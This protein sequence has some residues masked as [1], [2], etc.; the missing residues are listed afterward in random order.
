MQTI[1]ITDVQT[2]QPAENNNEILVFIKD[3]KNAIVCNYVEF[4][5]SNGRIILITY[6]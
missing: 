3:E 5:H 2:I 6:R 4:D 1:A